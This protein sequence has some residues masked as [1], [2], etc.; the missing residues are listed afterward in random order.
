MDE[1]D[2]EIAAQPIT[3]QPRPSAIAE[4]L[5]R[6]S[7]AI[8]PPPM[9]PQIHDEASPIVRTK[10][11]PIGPRPEHQ[12]HASYMSE[13]M[14]ALHEE[15]EHMNE[16]TSDT[17]PVPPAEIDTAAENVKHALKKIPKGSKR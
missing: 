9:P 11:A 17:L 16:Q 5:P 15:V 1:I 6:L 8:A 2:F 14:A 12:G 10:S 3:G 7:A 13:Q 4:E